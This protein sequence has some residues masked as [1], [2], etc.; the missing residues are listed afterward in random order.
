MTSASII[1]DGM[2]LVEYGETQAVRDPLLAETLNIAGDTQREGHFSRADE[3]LCQVFA[4]HKLCDLPFHVLC[5]ITRRIARTLEWVGTCTIDDIIKCPLVDMRKWKNF[6]A[7]S[8]ARLG[9]RLR[10]F[11]LNLAGQSDYDWISQRPS[12]DKGD[13]ANIEHLVFLPTF[14]FAAQV[15]DEDSSS[16]AIKAA[17]Y[18]ICRACGRRQPVWSTRC[19][20]CLS[21]GRLH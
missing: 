17:R 3:I 8:Q 7:L 20:H 11:G 4:N 1:L 18:F 12:R 19:A 5:P 21:I 6:G 15:P 10:T 13:S 9:R 2:K 14:V 16:E